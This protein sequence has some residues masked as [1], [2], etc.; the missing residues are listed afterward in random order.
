MS[1]KQGPQKLPVMMWA[2]SA[3]A[4]LAWGLGDLTCSAIHFVS[5]GREASGGGPKRR[6]ARPRAGYGIEP[7][8]VCAGIVAAIMFNIGEF[9]SIGRVS[10]RMLRHYDEI[11]LLR[12]L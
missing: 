4:P 10:V 11:G 7:H 5:W 6:N 8:A 9:A 12:P 3:R 2:A 1:H